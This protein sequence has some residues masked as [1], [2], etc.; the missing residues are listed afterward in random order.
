MEL[1]ELC[2]EYDL[3]DEVRQ[4]KDA[5]ETVF[6]LNSL[7]L[8]RNRNNNANFDLLLCEVGETTNNALRKCRNCGVVDFRKPMES[9]QKTCK[10]YKFNSTSADEGRDYGRILN[11]RKD[12]SINTKY[13]NNRSTTKYP[14]TRNSCVNYRDRYAGVSQ[15][16]IYTGKT[17]GVH[18]VNANSSKASDWLVATKPSFSSLYIAEALSTMVTDVNFGPKD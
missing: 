2:I 8:Q 17:K 16:K 6:Q 9:H 12:Y 5:D 15:R 13:V 3:D 4:Q 11:R 18:S 1:D 14:S 7:S 10:T